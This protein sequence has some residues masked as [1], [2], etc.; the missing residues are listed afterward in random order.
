MVRSFIGSDC[1]YEKIIKSSYIY[2]NYLLKNH[3]KDNG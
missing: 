2:G 1:N 3:R